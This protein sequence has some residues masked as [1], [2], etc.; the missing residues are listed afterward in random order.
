MWK[1]ILILIIMYLPHKSNADVTIDNPHT[2]LELITTAKDLLSSNGDLETVIESL[3]GILLMPKNEYTKDAKFLIGIAHER[4]GKIEKAKH[5]YATYLAE[6]PDSDMTQNIRQRLIALEIAKPILPINT[7]RSNTPNTGSSSKVSGSVSAYYYTGSTSSNP[8]QWKTT[9]ESSVFNLNLTGVFKENEYLTRTVFRYTNLLNI[10]P[11]Q[12]DRGKISV[13]YVDISDTYRGY[14]IKVGRQ[15]PQPGILGR[16]DGI[17]ATYRISRDAD[18]SL[19]SGTPYTGSVDNRHF[20]GIQFNQNIT[21]EF[22]HTLYYNYQLVDKLPE[23]SAI[24]SQLRYTKNDTSI[25]LIT[26][27]DTMYKAIN[28]ILLQGN[29]SIDSFNLYTMLNRQRSPVLFADRALAIDVNSTN[30]LPYLSVRDM[31]ANTKFSSSDLYQYISQTTPITTTYVIG[32]NKQVTNHWSV[33]V[34][35]QRSGTTVVPDTVLNSIL[36]PN[37]IK[38]SD[39]GNTT[40]VG[41]RATGTDF[42]F[43]HNTLDLLAGISKDNIS[44]SVS[45][46]VLDSKSIN[47]NV[48]I[49]F[50][51]R[52]NKREQNNQNTVITASSIRFNHRYNNAI[53]IESQIEFSKNSVR[54]KI[55]QSTNNQYNKTL[56]IGIR[57][58]F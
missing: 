14:G 47:D 9:Q 16:F 53:S 29:T 42:F 58:D 49:D 1:I 38:L 25:M 11:S 7:L 54:D 28:S 33:S 19:Q 2:P 23:R 35:L 18:I 40:S 32:V 20:Y 46:T 4:Q 57:Y 12:A 15:N 22:I 27:Y 41:M 10:Q 45:Y 31:L 39:A 5:D 3:N 30:H 17:S 51:V 36:D 55:A 50:L 37:V 48:R 52:Y 21:S 43:R 34:D 44:K 6:Y 56:L 8:T 26:E 13:A 24:G